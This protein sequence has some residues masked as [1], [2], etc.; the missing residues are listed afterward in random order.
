V[1]PVPLG[2]LGRTGWN[3]SRIG[4]GCASFWAR[5]TFSE[6]RARSVFD[7]ALECGITVFDTG[8]SYAAGAAEERLGR[9]LASAGGQSA[10]RLFVATKAGTRTASSGRIVRD[11]G[12]RAVAVQVEDSLRRLGLERIA[13][14]QLHGPRP[15]DL[16]DDLISSLQRLRRDGKLALLGINAEA[17][18][19]E[20]LPG[21]SEFDVLMPFVSVLR[22]EGA[23]LAARAGDAGLG[24]LAA[25][26]LA[27]M[28]FAPPWHRWLMRPSGV[29][30][31]ARALA[32]RLRAP[33]QT[34]P[35]MRR[36]RRAL[37]ADGWTP[38]QLALAWVLARPGISSAVFGTTRP[39]H[40][41]ELARAATRPLPAAVQSALTACLSSPGDLR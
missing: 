37:K 26:P 25:E 11:F 40:V 1:S 33:A 27:R 23:T 2:P 39:E 13:L 5:P 29:W 38:A 22:P 8:A 30:Y 3:V 17:A 35:R 32:A 16:D 7:A 34:A 41:H 4:L 36:I 31:L 18:V 14:L 20:Q 6:Q 9:M 21:R 24:V 12:A 10:D 19:L 15:E 28:R